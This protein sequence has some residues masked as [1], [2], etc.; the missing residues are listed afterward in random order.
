MARASCKDTILPV[1]LFSLVRKRHAILQQLTAF[2]KPYKW[3]GT[4]WL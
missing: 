1:M 2:F 4:S 3:L